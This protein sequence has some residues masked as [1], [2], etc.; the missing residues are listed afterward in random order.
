MAEA[1]DLSEAERSSTILTRSGDGPLIV[2][3]VMHGHGPAIEQRI[4]CLGAGRLGLRMTAQ[5]V[6]AISVAVCITQATEEGVVSKDVPA[7]LV[8]REEV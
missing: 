4:S 3:E 2:P 5:L 1:K 8:I 7:R 6:H